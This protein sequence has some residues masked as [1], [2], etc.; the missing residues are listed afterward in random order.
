MP[1]AINDTTIYIQCNNDFVGKQWKSEPNLSLP[2]FHSNKVMFSII[3]SI[4]EQKP[5]VLSGG[6][7]LLYV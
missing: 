4:E 1:I 5:T 6:K 3:P 7:L 2:P